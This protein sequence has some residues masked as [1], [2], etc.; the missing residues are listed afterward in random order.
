MLLIY[1]QCQRKRQS[2]SPGP[3]HPTCS[4]FTLLL[5][6]SPFKEEAFLT[7]HFTGKKKLHLFTLNYLLDGRLSHV[8]LEF[9]K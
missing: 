5:K 1:V 3:E 6:P 9:Q 2:A 8:L 4:L 7:K